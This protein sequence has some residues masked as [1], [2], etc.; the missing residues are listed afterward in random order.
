[1]VRYFLQH[2][3]LRSLDRASCFGEVRLFSFKLISYFNSLQHHNRIIEPTS[4]LDSY[5]AMQ[6]VEVLHKVA[7]AGSSVIFTIHQPASEIFN[8]F[9]HLILLNKGRSMYQVCREIFQF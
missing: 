1:M 3:I 9:N 8:S 5:S 6:L 7:N 2:F 4:G